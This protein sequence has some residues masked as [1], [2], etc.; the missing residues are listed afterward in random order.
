MFGLKITRWGIHVV[1]ILQKEEKMVSGYTL[2]WTFIAVLDL[3]IVP[4]S[5]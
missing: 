4:R 1:W 3:V 2:R 5:T